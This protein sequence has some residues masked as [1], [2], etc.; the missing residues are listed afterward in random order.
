MDGSCVLGRG[1]MYIY[2]IVDGSCV[3][4]EGI[5]LTNHLYVFNENQTRKWKRADAGWKI[6]RRTITRLIDLDEL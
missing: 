3:L 6:G 4:G 1:Y 5:N 2:I